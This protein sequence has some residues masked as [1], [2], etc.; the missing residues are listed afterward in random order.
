MQPY[1]HEVQGQLL[2]SL[3]RR[4]PVLCAP[5]ALV[6]PPRHGS[7]EIQWSAGVPGLYDLAD[8]NV[9]LLGQRELSPTFTYEC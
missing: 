5:G 9:S 3:P 2:N 1:R 7:I 6:R 4:N 8:E